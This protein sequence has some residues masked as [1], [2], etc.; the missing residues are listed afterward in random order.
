[1]AH[2]RQPLAP[3]PE[4]KRVRFGDPSRA[5]LERIALQDAR[6][7][8]DLPDLEDDRLGEV[9]EEFLSDD[10]DAVYTFPNVGGKPLTKDQAA[11]RNAVFG[12]LTQWFITVQGADWEIQHTH[13]N[14]RAIAFRMEQGED[15]DVHEGFHW[16]ICLDLKAARSLTWVQETLEV[17]NAR[18]EP[19]RDWEHA[20]AYITKDRTGIPET[21]FSKGSPSLGKQG[22]R[23]DI[24]AACEQALEGKWDEMV[25]SMIVRYEKGIM[26]FVA[27]KLAKFERK[28]PKIVVIFG[29]PRTFKSCFVRKMWPGAYWHK[30][31]GTG[32]QHWFGGYDPIM[33]KTVV[34]DD[35]DPADYPLSLTLSLLDVHP[36]T[37]EPKGS[38]VVFIPETVV[39]TT[40]VHPRLWYAMHKR[41]DANK[42]VTER[43][44][45]FMCSNTWDY[46]PEIDQERV[47]EVK[48]A[49]F[50]MD[51][52]FTGAKASV[53]AEPQVYPADPVFTVDDVYETPVVV[54][55]VLPPRRGAPVKR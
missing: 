30:S 1:M 18:C 16:H 51:E 55:K 13:K 32:G 38:Q 43:V 5:E 19:M 12:L 2:L 33:H 22:K 3:V 49:N 15:G 21:F 40:N 29:A 50:L 23:T 10:E 35:F 45:E 31:S 4:R 11:K 25:P 37:V 28:P 39:I 9:D 46:K 24:D 26:G 48:L 34:L 44:T 6:D 17:G 14:I 53:R 36:A 20:L 8:G 41:K 7:L 54:S 27:R 47:A 42:A 52:S